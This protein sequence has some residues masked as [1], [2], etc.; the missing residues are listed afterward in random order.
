MVRRISAEG[1][2]EWRRRSVERYR[3][4]RRVESPARANRA[5]EL[6]E[7]AG[8]RQ[9]RFVRARGRCEVCGDKLADDWQS[10]HVVRRSHTVIHDVE[11]L[12][13][14]HPR[15]HARIHAEVAWAK[16]QGFISTQ[17]RKMQ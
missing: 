1:L 12:M 5:A 15:C 3:A 17:W 4:R 8:E 13:V 11:N 2:K 14:V 9:K 10:H 16:G 7:Y 6:A